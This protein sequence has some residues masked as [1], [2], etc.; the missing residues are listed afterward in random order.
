[1]TFNTINTLNAAVTFLLFLPGVLALIGGFRLTEDTVSAPFAVAEVIAAAVTFLL[2]ALPLNV[3]HFEFG[4]PSAEL[5]VI[6]LI[7]EGIAVVLN[8]AV[9]LLLLRKGTSRALLMAAV[10]IPS[11][12][13]LLNG[14]V[15]RHPLLFVSAAVL[16]GCTLYHV[17]LETEEEDD[18]ECENG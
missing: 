6:T 13:F 2:M 3:T 18:E 12:V 16:F 15:L 5:F 8:D 14:A 4:F 7:A 9:W 11:A 17:L 10:I 1:M